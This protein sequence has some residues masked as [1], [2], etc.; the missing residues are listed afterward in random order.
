M[1]LGKTYFRPVKIRLRSQFRP[2]LIYAVGCLQQHYDVQECMGEHRDWRLCQDQ[3]K[4][5]KECISKSAKLGASSN[6]KT[7]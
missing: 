2:H 3:V 6:A 7:L 5:F 1:Q 4:V